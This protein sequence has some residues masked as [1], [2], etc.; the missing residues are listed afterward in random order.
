[1]VVHGAA[2]MLSSL[3]FADHAS[4]AAADPLEFADA[5]E[6]LAVAAARYDSDLS[7]VLAPLLAATA[8]SLRAGGPWLREL[9]VP[10][11]APGAPEWSLAAIVTLRAGAA[12]NA[13]DVNTLEGTSA[14]ALELFRRLGDPWGIA[15]AAQL[16]AEWLVMAGRLEEA[17]RIAEDAA[18]VAEGLTSIADAVQQRA[19]VVGI[20][21]RLGRWDEARAVLADI[22]AFARADGSARALVAAQMAAAGLHIAAG[23][24]GSALAALRQD[25]D[26]SW[27][28]YPEQIRAWWEAKRAQALVLLGRPAEAR[29][30]LRRAV[31]PARSSGDQPIAAEVATAIAGWL[32]ATGRTEDAVQALAVSAGLRGG[33]DA[34]DRF[35]AWVAERAEAAPTEIPAD[36]ASAFAAL[37]AVLD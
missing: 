14:Q 4:D 13:G 37:A 33:I 35:R 7:A 21:A 8:Q 5:A 1:M 11:P 18:V 25:P 23:D 36:A 20:L 28:G 2:L 27:D 34:T 24:G 15:F 17:L 22:E 30:A 9:T 31:D 10:D 16:R 32:V 26:E 12:Q 6:R 29:D 3:Q 19:A